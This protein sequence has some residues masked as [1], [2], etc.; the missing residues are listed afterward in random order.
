LIGFDHLLLAA[1]VAVVSL[2]AWRGVD[3]LRGHWQ[4]RRS[5][6]L[7]L[8]GSAPP[9][10]PAVEGMIAR[11]AGLGFERLGVTRSGRPILGQR[12]TA[13]ILVDRARTSLAEITVLPGDREAICGLS[14]VFGDGGVLVTAHGFGDD[15]RKRAL[16]VQ[17]VP[18]GPEDAWQRH[19][20][21]LGAMSAR[22]GTPVR[23]RDMADVMR[24]EA[25]IRARLSA[26]G[27][28]L[29]RWMLGGWVAGGLIV[30][31]AIGVTG[32]RAFGTTDIDTWLSGLGWPMVIGLTVAILPTLANIRRL[33]GRS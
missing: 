6:A 20:D 26:Y 8:S 21:A 11:L 17:A 29:D 2:L 10:A 5:F 15:V 4:Y 14:T 13:W 12:L 7:D 3:G 27:F 25:T 16:V 23:L 1:S 9:P 24:A 22:H 18:T 33:L 31:G 28:G 30:W 32:A 19:R